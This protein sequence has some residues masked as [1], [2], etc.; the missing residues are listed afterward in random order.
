MIFNFYNLNIDVIAQLCAVFFGTVLAAPLL[1]SPR[2]DRRHWGFTMMMV[3]SLFALFIHAKLALWVL[4]AASIFWFLMA[5]RGW[6]STLADAP[7]VDTVV[8]IV[9]IVEAAA[10]TQS[11]LDTFGS[12]NMTPQ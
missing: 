6:F 11:L 3:G 5:L 2:I 10:P 12:N 7:S 8:E 4:A 9:D 1:S